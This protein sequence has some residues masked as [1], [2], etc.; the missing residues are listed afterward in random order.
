M[1]EMKLVP[2][3]WAGGPGSQYIKNIW[4][5]YKLTL[6]QFN[7][8]WSMQD[9]KCAGCLSAFAHPTQRSNQLGVRPEVDHDHITMQVRGLL[10]R[11]CNDFLGKVRDNKETLKRLEEY[12]RRN[13]E[14]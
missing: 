12:L 1:A 9:A 2:W 10:C 6:E 3:G 4:M 13:G 11:R 7:V 8:L 5:S 14:W